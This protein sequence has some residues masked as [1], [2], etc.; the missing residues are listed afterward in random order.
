MVNTFIYIDHLSA[1]FKEGAMFF[2]RNHCFFN[3]C[4]FLR[5]FVFHVGFILVYVATRCLA[6]LRVFN[7]SG[8]SW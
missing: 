7:L 2:L 3:C 5:I 8:T 1:L 4:A 6:K